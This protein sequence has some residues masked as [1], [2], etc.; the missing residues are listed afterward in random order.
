MKIVDFD[1]KRDKITNIIFGMILVVNLI[2]AKDTHI[3][4]NIQKGSLNRLK[5]I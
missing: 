3:I 5:V 2:F 1:N 4:E